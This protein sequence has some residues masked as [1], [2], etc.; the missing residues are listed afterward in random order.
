MNRQGLLWGVV[1]LAIVGLVALGVTTKQQSTQLAAISNALTTLTAKQSSAPTP[2]ATETKPI[3]TKKTYTE[4]GF[5]CYYGNKQLTLNDAKAVAVLDDVLKKGNWQPTLISSVQTCIP[6]NNLS[7]IKQALVATSDCPFNQPGIGECSKAAIV[8]VDLNAKTSRVIVQEPTDEMFGPAVFGDITQWTP[9]SV[10]YEVRG[11]FADG[12]CDTEL[13]KTTPA[14]TVKTASIAT[15][16][17]DTVKV[18]K[19]TTCSDWAT[20]ECTNQ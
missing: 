2:V 14:Y 15:G 16:T 11:R 20:L 17:P 19:H 3:E 1:G 7:T 18:C 9:S 5:D 10:S 12:G 6:S 13:I 4:Y 8:L